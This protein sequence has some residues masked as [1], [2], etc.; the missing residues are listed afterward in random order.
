MDFG[1]S[2]EQQ[3]LEQTL[4]RYLEEEVATTRVREICETESAHDPSLWSGLAELGIAGVLIPEEH[5]GSGLA[6]LDAA[7]AAESLGWGV[8]PAPLMPSWFVVLTNVKSGLPEVP[9][10]FEK[11]P[12]QL[13]IA[14][15]VSQASIVQ[16]PASGLPS[17]T[18]ARPVPTTCVP[19]ALWM[20]LNRAAV[21]SSPT[22]PGPVAVKFS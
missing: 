12:D 2:E 18:E 16:S 9:A 1:L 19:L 8:T 7:V 6:L 3:L 13:Y 20:P 4:R 21:S 17:A 22:R 11:T 14:S 10:L 15:W 5:G